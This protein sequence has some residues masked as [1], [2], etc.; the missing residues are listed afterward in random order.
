MKRKAILAGVM[1]SLLWNTYLVAGGAIN[2]KSL[3][4]RIAGGQYTS[5]PAILQFIYVIETAITLFQFYFVLRLYR[6][7]GAWSKNSYLITRVFL[8]LSAL[9][10][11]VNVVSKSHLERWNTIAAVVIAL[12]Y[13]VLGNVK[14]KPT[15]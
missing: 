13:Y 2:A 15:H 4:P 7:G 11:L 1:I 14:F 8:A 3:L 10:A 5:L 6:L 12:G 9:S